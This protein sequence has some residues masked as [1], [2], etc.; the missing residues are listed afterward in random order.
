MLMVCGLSPA[1][2]SIVVQLTLY[3]QLDAGTPCALVKQCRLTKLHQNDVCCFSDYQRPSF[4]RPLVECYDEA[5][6]FAGRSGA[7]TNQKENG[8]EEFSREALSGFSGAPRCGPNSRKQI[9]AM[10]R[11]IFLRPM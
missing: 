5:P 3:F 1:I 10:Q 4:L 8:P 7:K 6:S 11:A 2:G 9:A